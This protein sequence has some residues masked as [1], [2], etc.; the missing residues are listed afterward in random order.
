METLEAD[1]ICYLDH[2]NTDTFQQRVS[3]N[4]DGSDFENL[5][6][7]NQSP[8]GHSSGKYI[9][10]KYFGQL[11]K[12][13]M[14][15]VYERYKEDFLLHGYKIDSFYSYAASADVGENE[16]KLWWDNVCLWNPCF[17]A[18]LKSQEDIEIE[19]SPFDYADL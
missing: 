11:P 18:R 6:H 5:L 1:I 3:L 8:K 10:Q 14:K 19:L 17:F 7:V 16:E 13:L 9:R 2:N 4:L 15:M 12:Q